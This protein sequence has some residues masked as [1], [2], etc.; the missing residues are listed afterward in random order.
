MRNTAKVVVEGNLQSYIHIQEKLEIHDS[1]HI[2]MLEKEQIK[3]KECAIEK[4]I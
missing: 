3:P 1:F 4:I 2:K